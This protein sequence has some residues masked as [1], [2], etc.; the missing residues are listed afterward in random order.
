KQGWIGVQNH[1][2]EISFRNIEIK[3]LK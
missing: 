3:E 1:G 2:G